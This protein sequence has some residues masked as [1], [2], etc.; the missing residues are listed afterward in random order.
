M[1]CQGGN[2]RKLQHQASAEN[3]KPEF[4]LRP[5]VPEF[6]YLKKP[7]DFCSLRK[8]RPGIGYCC[9]WSE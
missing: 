4:E 3:G 9:E 7:S 2:F 6:S 5:C 1:E 8:E